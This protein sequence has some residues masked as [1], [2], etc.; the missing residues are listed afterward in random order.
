MLSE[1]MIPVLLKPE[2]FY[3]GLV[4]WLEPPNIITLYN[5]TRQGETKFKHRT[6]ERFFFNCIECLNE[7]AT[8]GNTVPPYLVDNLQ[9]EKLQT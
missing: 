3:K 2:I 5:Q 4:V 8:F 7:P 6:R 1:N 9:M